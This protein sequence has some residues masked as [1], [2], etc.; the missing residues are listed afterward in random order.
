M[1]LVDHFDG[2]SAD[3][4]REARPR[5]DAMEIRIVLNSKARS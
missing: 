2:D 5:M 3:A 1:W 4:T